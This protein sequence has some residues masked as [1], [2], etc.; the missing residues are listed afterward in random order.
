MEVRTTIYIHV[1]Y[2]SSIILHKQTIYHNQINIT[3][4]T[5]SSISTENKQQAYDTDSESSDD[6][7][8]SHNIELMPSYSSHS[9]ENPTQ[10]SHP[11]ENSIQPP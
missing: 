6:L 9:S 1:G 3:T 2:D 5:H 4:P 8:N 11:S 10:L 7:E